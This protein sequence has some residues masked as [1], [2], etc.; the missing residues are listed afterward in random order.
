MIDAFNLLT[1]SGTEV[2][3][4]LN[5]M[6]DEIN[7]IV[8]DSLQFGTTIPANMEPMIAQLIKQG[9]LTDKNG[10]KIT[11]MSQI[12]FG[13]KVKDEYETIHGAIETILKA[14][15]DLIGKIDS[16]VSAID[17]ATRDRTMTVTAQYY[18]PGP[19][20]GFG[21]T[22]QSRGRETS[23]EGFASGTMGK[24]G[25]WFANF[26]SGT[27]AV[28]HGREAV[29]RSDQAAAFASDMGAG[30]NADVTA[31][32]AGLRQ[33]LN[34]ILPRAISRALRDALQLSGAV[35]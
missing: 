2:G 10:Q 24:M 26:G 27:K 14:M 9:D 13:E 28:L 7:N 34:S 18:D 17:A 15:S 16:L 31:E 33:D 3:V 19:P 25:S 21:E 23:G 11:D 8:R 12:K 22:N 6:K 4:V 35:A 30:S 5:G 20:A 29:I 32:I 1:M